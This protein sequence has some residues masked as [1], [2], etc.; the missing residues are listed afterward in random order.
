MG[1]EFLQRCGRCFIKFVGYNVITEQ[2]GYAG[3]SGNGLSN[4]PRGS[5]ASHDFALL[6]V[7]YAETRPHKSFAPLLAALP[8]I[9]CN[10]HLRTPLSILITGEWRAYIRK[11]QRYHL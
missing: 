10:A 11:M 3:F 5:K 8:L 6:R 2:S 7:Y 9:P 4:L 1:D